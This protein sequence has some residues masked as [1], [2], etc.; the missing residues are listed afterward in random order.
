MPRPTTKTELIAATRD[1]WAALWQTIDTIPGGPEA[2]VLD[3]GGDPKLTEA[4][5][6]RDTD[7]HDVLVHLHAWHRL[8]LDWV[9]ANL[10]GDPR[11]FLPP[12]YTWANYGELNAAIR[13]A[14]RDS[15]YRE[16]ADQARASHAELLALA[17]SFSE[18]E[19]FEKKHFPW[20]GSTHLASYL[21]SASPSHSDWAIKKI[22]RALRGR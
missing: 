11:P 3:F 19:L 6:S 1:R 16:A 22:R 21:I 15:S 4:H 18:Q 8:A 9:A 2:L 10:G 14:H 17:E 13:T 20:T 7:L 12:P 5:W